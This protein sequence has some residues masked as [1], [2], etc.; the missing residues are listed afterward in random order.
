MSHYT[1][2]KRPGQRAAGHD[3]A[4]PALQ[5]AVPNSAALSQV[6]ERAQAQIPAAEAEADRLSASVSSGGPEAVK[7]AIGRRLGADF[8]GVRF[9]TG[10]TAEAKASAMDARAYTSG[11]DIYFGAG[12]FDPAVAAH[13]LVHTVQQ[14]AVAAATPTMSTPMGGVQRVPGFTT[15]LELDK[16]RAYKKDLGYQNIRKLAKQFNS[17]TTIQQRE[18]LQ[19]ELLNAGNTYIKIHSQAKGGKGE[20][21]GRQQQVQK[22]LSQVLRNQEIISNA[23]AGDRSQLGDIFAQGS[24]QG[25]LFQ[26][27]VQTAG[28]QA[29]ARIT[30]GAGVPQ[31]VGGRYNHDDIV[32]LANEIA[33]EMKD[34]LDPVL[35]QNT[36]RS[37]DSSITALQG[38]QN[39]GLRA[40]VDDELNHQ[41]LAASMGLVHPDHVGDN[42]TPEE[43]IRAN[44]AGRNMAHI[45]LAAQ[46][47]KIDIKN[48]SQVQRYGANMEFDPSMASLFAYGGRTAFDLGGSSE[49]KRAHDVYRS[50]VEKDSKDA[51]KK[52]LANEVTTSRFATHIL[53]GSELREGSKNPA[54]VGAAA[55]PLHKQRGFNLAIG[56]AGNEG[57]TALDT[58]ASQ[59]HTRDAN[60]NVTGHTIKAEGQE[61]HVYIGER[62]SLGSSHG[63]LLVGIE[64][65]GSGKTNLTGKAH[66]AAAVKAPFSSTGADKKGVY[67][68]E[69]GGRRVDLTGISQDE[70]VSLQHMLT[71]RM[72]ELAS[73]AYSGDAQALQNYNDMMYKLSGSKLS[74]KDLA[75]L[76]NPNLFGRRVSK[77]EARYRRV[78]IDT[79]RRAQA[80]GQ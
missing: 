43:A 68:D 45:M 67:G 18:A 36:S 59:D 33:P 26:E 41:A 49:K 27:L 77:D 3:A 56:G 72:D 25:S 14:G 15:K 66:T 48:G 61:G 4:K 70:Q 47:G 52:K 57:Y 54:A 11:A 75:K 1:Y 20:H 34:K 39:A 74:P 80:G 58:V 35:R 53:W 78:L 42:L 63:G 31:K 76:L 10:E 30:N 19:S 60:G 29:N 8:S 12:G 13:E 50:M 51:G 22:M 73:A 2:Q 71:R 32:R 24:G 21:L 38:R 79:I 55:S 44:Q 5:P 17:A 7:A 64:T 9:H 46:L 6:Q 69:Y 37:K 28:Q 65:S 62:N 23:R 16:S 40:A